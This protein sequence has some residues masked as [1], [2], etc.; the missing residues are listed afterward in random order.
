MDKLIGFDKKRKNTDSV[1]KVRAN[2]R[3]KINDYQ[4]IEITQKTS[5]NKQ[6]QQ[7]EDSG[8]KTPFGPKDI[9]NIEDS[10]FISNDDIFKKIQEKESQK[11]Q[12]S[13]IN[14]TN[15]KTDKNNK[16]G[17]KT[18]NDL[19]NKM[20]LTLCDLLNN[21]NGDD[22]DDDNAVDDDDN[23]NMSEETEGEESASQS[24]INASSSHSS[25]QSLNNNK[26]VTIHQSKLLQR[27]DSDD[28]DYTHSDA[29]LLASSASSQLYT[30]CFL[31]SWGNSEHDAIY[32]KNLEELK[33]MYMNLRPYTREED[34]A[35]MLHLY[36]M[37]KVWKPDSNMPILTPIMALN[38]IRNIGKTHTLNATEHI[39]D[40]IRLW[41]RVRDNLQY[42]MY[43]QDNKADK[44]QFNCLMNTQKILNSLYTMNIPKM[45]FKDPDC[46]INISKGPLFKIESLN[47]NTEKIIKT[48]KITQTNIKRKKSIE[49]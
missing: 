42:S 23:D 13:L 18:N 34:L 32:S 1:G 9:S 36:F 4:T 29:I 12:N 15:K 14:M 37:E 8:Q 25:S 31:C 45:L 11:Y 41:S 33:T 28:D 17:K 46:T 6:Q 44:D 22:D 27:D 43:H 20:N 7:E 40:S 30:E 39:I 48:K 35:N 38:H 21:I 5:Y 49:I 26:L 19:V 16:V 24:S 3:Q 2:K 10:F 47:E